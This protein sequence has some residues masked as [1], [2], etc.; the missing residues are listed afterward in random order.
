M[1]HSY[2]VNNLFM[3]ADE[4]A[5]C[6]GFL[7]PWMLVAS[8]AMMMYLHYRVIVSAYSLPTRLVD[9]STQFLGSVQEYRLESGEGFHSEMDSRAQGVV[10]QYVSAGVGAGVGAGMGRG[11]MAGKGIRKA[12]WGGKS[13]QDAATPGEWPARRRK[14]CTRAAEGAIRQ[15]RTA[16]RQRGRGRRLT[17]RPASSVQLARRPDGS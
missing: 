8:L 14:P 4:T 16:K 11:L 5:T 15:R 3:P 12:F 1:R 6:G 13:Q 10:G 2:A 9:M 7:D 17:G